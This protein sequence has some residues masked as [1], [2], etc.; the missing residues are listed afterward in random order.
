M[1]R[2]LEKEERLGVQGERESASKNLLDQQAI[3]QLMPSSGVSAIL[4]SIHTSTPPPLSLSLFPLIFMIPP[5]AMIEM[6]MV[7]NQKKKRK[8]RERRESDSDRD[9]EKHESC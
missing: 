6:I 9:R 4:S 8:E 5:N 1:N 3:Y 7:V 2:V